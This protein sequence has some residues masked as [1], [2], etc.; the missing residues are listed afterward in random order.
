[1]RSADQTFSAAEVE[2]QLR[3]LAEH[4]AECVSLRP[5]GSCGA[6]Q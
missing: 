6:W 5:Y 2:G 3:M 1:M 4:A